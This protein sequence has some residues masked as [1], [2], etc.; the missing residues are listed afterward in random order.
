MKQSRA[1]LVNLLIG[2]SLLEI[3][4]V[5]TLAVVV[6]VHAFPPTFEGWGEFVLETRSV[7]GWAVN[8]GAPW[9]RV[10]VQLFIDDK[11]YGTQLAETSR[12][13]VAA[14]GW[15][16]DEWHGYN[17]PLSDLPPGNHEARVYALHRDGDRMTL[18]LLGNPIRFAWPHR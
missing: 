4:L 8:Y 17:F 13:D 11:L 5:G 10:E 6:Y 7:A 9:D 18:Q 2:K 1:Q 15:A 14:A 16:K 12:P 3:V